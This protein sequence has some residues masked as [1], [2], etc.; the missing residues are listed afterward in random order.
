M[1]EEIE[2]NWLALGLCIFKKITPEQAILKFKGKKPLD[3]VCSD[4]MAGMCAMR[5]Q[6]MT[7]QAIAD[8]HGI[9]A[10]GVYRNIQRYAKKTG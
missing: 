3:D 8:L 10:S 5:E 6:G 4:R 2:D 9:T 7:L 1:N